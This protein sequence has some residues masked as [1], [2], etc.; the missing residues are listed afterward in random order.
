MKSNDETSSN[1]WVEASSLDLPNHNET[2]KLVKLIEECSEVI[3]A[4]TKIM[5]FGWSNAH[6]NR[7]LGQRNNL[8]DLNK[9]LSDLRRAQRELNVVCQFIQ[10]EEDI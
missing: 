9:E 8:G 10:F 1:N 4:A 6:P 7:S 3:Q 5:R 2:A